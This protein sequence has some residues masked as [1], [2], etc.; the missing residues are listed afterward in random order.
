MEHKP[1]NRH[2]KINLRSFYVYEKI[3]RTRSILRS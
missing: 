2:L 1:K 3:K